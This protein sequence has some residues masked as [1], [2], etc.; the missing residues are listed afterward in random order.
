VLKWRGSYAPVGVASEGK[1][2]EVFFVPRSTR[3]SVMIGNR[4]FF[5]D[6]LARDGR[7]ETLRVLRNEGYERVCLT[8]EDAK[9]GSMETLPDARRCADPL[10]QHGDKIDDVHISLPV[11]VTS[12]P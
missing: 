6:V 1:L 8:P 3:F 7:E 12:P 10:R 2:E 9:S 4:G 5:P 11:L